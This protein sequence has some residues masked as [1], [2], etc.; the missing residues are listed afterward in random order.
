MCHRKLPQCTEGEE[1]EKYKGVK[2]AVKN[3]VL[4]EEALRHYSHP[5]ELYT[6][7]VSCSAFFVFA[8]YLFVT[9]SFDLIALN[10]HDA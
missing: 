5:C 7:R 4:E 9:D 6:R 3:C 2:S 1:I 10:C 8:H